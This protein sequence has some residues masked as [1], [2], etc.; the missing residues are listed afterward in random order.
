MI[1]IESLKR[2]I[3]FAKIRGPEETPIGTI[4][5]MQITLVS[6]AKMAVC[7]YIGHDFVDDSQAGP[8]SGNMSGYCKRCGF[9]YSV[10]LY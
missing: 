4:K 7:G 5:A 10:T 2:D 1:T 6:R 8:E 9:S 3:E